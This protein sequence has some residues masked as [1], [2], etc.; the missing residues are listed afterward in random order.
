MGI[1]DKLFSKAQSNAK[2]SSADEQAVLIHLNGTDLDQEIYDEYDTSTLEDQLIQA[3]QEF[4]LGEFD[5]NETGPTNTTLYLYG[6]D[7]EKL[8]ICI[9]P[10]LR[11][12]PLCQRA[13]VV[14]RHGA[15][16]SFQRTVTL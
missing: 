13:E 9:E 8:F 14:I 4:G 3:L 1:F 12:Y 11:S 10:I 15:N 5:G 2:Q 16:G 6:P 7:A